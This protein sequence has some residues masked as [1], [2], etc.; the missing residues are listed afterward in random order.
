MNPTATAGLAIY[1]IGGGVV[2]ATTN[3]YHILLALQGITLFCLAAVL[4]TRSLRTSRGLATWIGVLG[5]SLFT[6]FVFLAATRAGPVNKAAKFRRWDALVATAGYAA[7]MGYLMTSVIPGKSIARYLE[8]TSIGIPTGVATTMALFDDDAQNLVQ[9]ADICT[10]VYESPT[11]RNA[12]TDT[13]ALVSESEDETIVA[14]AGTDSRYNVSTDVRVSD[15]SFGACGNTKTRVHSGF[16]NAWTSV[17][18]EVLAALAGK[19]RATFT[20]HSLGGALATLAGLDAQ[21]TIP[22]IQV[23]VVTFGSPQVGDELFVDEF[24]ARV[25]QSARVVTSLD[26][27]PRSLSSQFAHV[28]GVYFVPTTG[29]NPHGMETYAEAIAAPRTARMLGIVLPA[30]YL[31]IALS[32]L[33]A[34][35]R[36]R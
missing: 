26:P 7:A 32:V 5:A 29:I 2:L 3:D 18:S 36:G 33:H 27:V 16:L 24:N 25:A 17:R 23:R 31:V 20:G 1:G 9:Y 22:G 8:L 15:S 34:A 11:I 35:K 13:R 21:C 28:K 10:T 19:K 14:F 6:R 4:A 30:V 12:A